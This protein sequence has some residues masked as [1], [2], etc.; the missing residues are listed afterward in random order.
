LSLK[1]IELALAGDTVALRLCMDRIL[2]VRKG[3]PIRFPMPKVMTAGDVL[4]A[5]AAIT[6]QLLEAACHL[7]KR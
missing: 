2:P 1:C 3:R 5:L 7:M 6:E 4:G